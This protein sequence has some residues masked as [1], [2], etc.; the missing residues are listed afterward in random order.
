MGLDPL[1]V[2]EPVTRRIR[3]DGSPQSELGFHNRS[4]CPAPC[5]PSISSSGTV[6]AV[7]A[8]R[9][10]GNPSRGNGPPSGGRG[11]SRWDGGFNRGSNFSEG[12]PSGTAGG[13]GGEGT[14]EEQPFGDGV[15]RA[16]SGRPNNGGGGFRNQQGYNRGFDRRNY[17]NNIGY[18]TRRPYNYNQYV[19]RENTPRSDPDLSGL[20]DAQKKMV[21]DVAEAFARQLVAG[22][23]S[24]GAPEAVLAPVNPVP[25][26]G[27][28]AQRG[29]SVRRPPAAALRQTYV[30]RNTVAAG[31]GAADSD[32]D[33]VMQGS[34]RP[35]D[36]LMSVAGITQVDYAAKCPVSP[37]VMCTPVS[38]GFSKEELVR[39]P[40]L[41]DEEPKSH[42]PSATD[43]RESATLFKKKSAGSPLDLSFHRSWFGM[44]GVMRI[45]A[46]YLHDDS[47]LIFRNLIAFEQRHLK[48]SLSV[49]SYSICMA[50]LLQS[51]TD[52]KLLRKNRILAHTDKSDQEIVDFFKKLSGDYKDTFMPS[53]LRKLY[54]DVATHHDS[55]LAR[56][57]GGIML[58]Y[59]PTPW[60]TISIIGG[61]I[62]FF[63]TIANNI[64]SV[65]RYYHPR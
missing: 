21:K 32:G 12:G 62:I 8:N 29:T 22:S 34:A 2:I 10:G 24:S 57:C 15:F 9:G 4:F 26:Q 65:Y 61:A 39:S 41:L 25:A 58:Q 40:N 30:P 45:P 49:T 6:A 54:K 64:H 20:N 17:G 28:P 5:V 33:M 52:A 19:R 37:A 35:V 31:M 56:I 3:F 7:M 60:I 59:F 43:L 11:N 48:C 44:S 18:N 50:R 23:G 63:A 53:D 16:G 46:L 51:E 36:V 13:G 47:E 1:I 42:L 14:G 55:Q 27:P 38:Q